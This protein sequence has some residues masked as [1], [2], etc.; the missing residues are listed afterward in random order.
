ML[1]SKWKAFIDS[2][3]VGG[4]FTDSAKHGIGRTSTPVSG[5]ASYRIPP[6]IVGT[7]H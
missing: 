5:S 2:K 7:L 1:V 4:F 3:K 6:P